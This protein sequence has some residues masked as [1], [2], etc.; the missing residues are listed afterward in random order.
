MPVTAGVELCGAPQLT[1]ESVTDRHTMLSAVFGQPEADRQEQTGSSP[2][3]GSPFWTYLVYLPLRNAPKELKIGVP[4]DAHVCFGEDLSKC[5]KRR[6]SIST[7]RLWDGTSIQQGGVASRAGNEYDAVIGRVLGVDIHNFGFAGNGKM[8]LSVAKYLSMVEASVLVIDCLPN[9]DAEAVA[10][11][12]IPLVQYLRNNGHA[13]TPI[14]LAEGTPYPGEWLNGPP[15]MD[16]PKNVA[17]K[18]AFDTLVGPLGVTGLHYVKGTDLFDET[19]VNPTVGGVHSSDLG[20]YMIANFY[21]KFLPTI[22][23]ASWR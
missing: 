9:M 6:R 11:Q 1:C 2:D 13:T 4:S 12:T 18:K 20:Q 21:V 15:F 5:D 23:D 7:S 22:L 19:F 8:E 14:V 10:N 16:T 3:N 17:L